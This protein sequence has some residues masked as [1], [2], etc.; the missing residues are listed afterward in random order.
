MLDSSYLRAMLKQFLHCY[1]RERSLRSDGYCFV[2]RGNMELSGLQSSVPALAFSSVV[3]RL[4][5][6]E[7]ICHSTEWSTATRIS[8]GKWS[9]IETFVYIFHKYGCPQICP[10][11][12]VIRLPQLHRLWIIGTKCTNGPQILLVKIQIAMYRTAT[13]YN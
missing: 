7:L 10:P 4:C 1:I 5:K 13:Q 6:T 8:I 3:V 12:G 2:Y 11:Y 9:S